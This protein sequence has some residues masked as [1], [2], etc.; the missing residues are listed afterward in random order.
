M[1]RKTTG[2]LLN[3][4]GYRIVRNDRIERNSLVG[5]LKNLKD[6]GANP[7]SII[8]GGAAYGKY[9]QILYGLFPKARYILVE[10]LREYEA[11]INANCT[12]EK[13]IV[14]KALSS[15]EG[16]MKI[17]LHQDLVGSS[18][19][20]EQEGEYVDGLEREVQ[21]TTIDVIAEE[22]GLEPPFLIKLD[23]QGAELDALRG[24]GKTL[25][26]HDENIVVLEVCMFDF[27]IGSDNRFK[28][29]ISFMDGL[30]YELHDV[31][32]LAYRPIDNALAQVDCVFCSKRSMLRRVSHYGYPEFRE[33]QFK[34]M[35]KK[36]DLALKKIGRKLD[37]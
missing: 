29:V 20:K 21:V 3:R 6:N 8:D 27:F 19:Y 16:K 31:Y 30:D 23:L 25:S 35:K 4:L 34:Q 28:K 37:D 26:K 33:K 24:A 15:S 32:G 17:N 5:V 36:H 18:L 11:I 1:I 12:F 22:Y 7:N 13:D 2:Y 14:W 9:S 10:P